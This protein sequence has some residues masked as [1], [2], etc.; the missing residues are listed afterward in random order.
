MPV[1]YTINGKT[2]TITDKCFLA[3]LLP[4]PVVHVFDAGGGHVESKR[5]KNIKDAASALLR[6]KRGK[7][8]NVPEQE[9]DPSLVTLE[10]SA[11]ELRAAAWA[12]ARLKISRRE[13]WQRAVRGIISDAVRAEIAAGRDVPQDIAETLRGD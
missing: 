9:H 10:L 3:L 7:W 1:T 13:F 11:A 12:M 8:L 2:I 4:E 5:C 6:A